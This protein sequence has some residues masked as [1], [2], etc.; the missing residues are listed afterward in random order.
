MICL[1]GRVSHFVRQYS[2]SSNC[3]V[4]SMIEGSS[5]CSVR[6]SQTAYD[7]RERVYLAI[8]KARGDCENMTVYGSD[9]LG[10]HLLGTHAVV[11]VTSVTDLDSSASHF[12]GEPIGGN[13]DRAHATKVNMISL[14]KRNCLGS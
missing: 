1:F 6:S 13:D 7:G 3:Y 10:S 9:L 5:E 14:L 8:G 12:L 2:S 11:S 4:S